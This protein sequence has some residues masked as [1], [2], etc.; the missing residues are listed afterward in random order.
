VTRETLVNE[1]RKLM[2]SP[3]REEVESRMGE[4]EA[5][6]RAGEDRWFSELCFCLLT[7][8]FTAEG[9][10]RIQEAVGGGFATLG[11]PEL[12]AELARLGHRFP[13]A[14]AA[15]IV[16]AREKLGILKKVV[17]EFHSGKV[18]REWVAGVK[19][20]GMKEASHFLRNVGFRD[21]AI[22]DRHILNLLLEHGL[23]GDRKL[24]WERYLQIERLLEKLGGEL[25][26]DLARLD[27]Y[28]WF[29]KTGKVLK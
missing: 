9:G 3:L 6:G 10:I 18:A 27:L 13:K 7:A 8:N 15:Y 20:L 16:Q 26:L 2:D 22:V 23:I 24:N 19:G 21:V 4:F 5:V 11:E 14:R 17:G 28:L 25:G 29:L 12:A 1:V